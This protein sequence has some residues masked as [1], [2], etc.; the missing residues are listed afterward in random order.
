[1][2]ISPQYYLPGA[3]IPKIFL[4]AD[5]QINE[6]NPEPNI[7]TKPKEVPMPFIEGCKGAKGPIIVTEDWYVKAKKKELA[8]IA[9]NKKD[10][11]I[12]MMQLIADKDRLRYKLGK[13]DASRKKDSKMIVAINVKIKDIDAE[14]KALQDIAGVN[15]DHLDKGSRFGRFVG[16]VKKVFRTVK[17]AVKHWY[18][19]HED[20]IKGVAAIVLPVLLSAVVKKLIGLFA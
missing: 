9:Q 20:V 17:K 18:Y 14:L 13:L 19:E 2:L 5:R 10:A 11:Q 3:N 1:M 12:E 6:A 16:K 7:V 8:R 4:E 15:I